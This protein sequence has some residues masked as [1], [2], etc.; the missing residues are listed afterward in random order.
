MALPGVL[1]GCNFP[2]TSLS[3]PLAFRALKI[4]KTVSTL[5]TCTSFQVI[6]VIL[7][8]SGG[9]CP[10]VGSDLQSTPYSIFPSAGADTSI[11]LYCIDI[12]VSMSHRILSTDLKDVDHFLAS[13]AVGTMVAF[14]P[15]SISSQT[16]SPGKAI[17][18]SPGISFC[19]SDKDDRRI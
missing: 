1:G 3:S 9:V 8:H 11:F 15:P 13:L 4:S 16:P 7:I 2:K 14:D 12:S 17:G 18:I 5:I 19:G 10:S 6:H